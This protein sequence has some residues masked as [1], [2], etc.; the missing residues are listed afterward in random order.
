MKNCFAY[1]SER[2]SLFLSDNYV[3]Q[4]HGETDCHL[5]YIDRLLAI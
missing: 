4:N 3:N 2:S 1:S 5:L